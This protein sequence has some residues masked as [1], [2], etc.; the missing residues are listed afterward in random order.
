MFISTINGTSG[1]SLTFNLQGHDPDD[2][3]LLTYYVVDDGDG[4][5]EVDSATGD[6]TLAVN[7]TRPVSFR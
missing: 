3:D 5:V 4:A 1:Q 7:S 6:V 2:G